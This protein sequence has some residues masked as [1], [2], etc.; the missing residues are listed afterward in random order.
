MKDTLIYPNFNIN[1]RGNLVSLSKPLIM[2]VLNVNF[3]SFYSSSR[4]AGK[5]EFIPRIA[6]MIEDGMDI[7]DLGA[8]SSRPGADFVPEEEEKRR[9]EGVISEVMKEFPDLILSVDTFRSEIAR[10]SVDQGVS[11]INDISGGS[12][13]D[14]MF[15]TIAEL[16]VPYILMHMRGTP[17]TMKE[18]TDYKD[19]LKEIYQYFDKKL[20]QLKELGVEDVVLDLGYGFAKNLDQNYFLLNHQNYFQSLNRPILT[21]ISRKSMIYKLLDSTPEQALN[22]TSVL[23]FKALEKGANILRVHD[24]REAKE[25]VKIFEKLTTE[26]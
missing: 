19:I 6:K 13:D 11:I 21:G 23:N 20:N 12:L 25:V 5:K 4:I 2:G 16:K 14:K 1:C 24:V 9:L 15:K 26:R 10:F 18:M 3:D 17:Q 22:G 8:Y 7:L